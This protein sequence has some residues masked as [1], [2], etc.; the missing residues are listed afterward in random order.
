MKY[1]GRADWALMGEIM[2][3]IYWS[4]FGED[5]GNLYFDD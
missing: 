3:H 1:W 5:K 2:L 4:S